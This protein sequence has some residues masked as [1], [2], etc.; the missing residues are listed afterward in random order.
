MSLCPG[1][2]TADAAFL[3]GKL[4]EGHSMAGPGKE[5]SGRW[6]AAR[7]TDTTSNAHRFQDL[8]ETVIETQEVWKE[9]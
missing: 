4:N 1:T 3:A 9:S 2:E 6:C 5:N 8:K 7:A